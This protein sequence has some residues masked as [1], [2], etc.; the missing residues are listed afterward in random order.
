MFRS[1]EIYLKVSRQEKLDREQSRCE[2]SESYH[3]GDCL[4][5]RTAETVGCQ[6]FWSNLTGHPVCH[7]FQRL[8]SYTE[9][10][11]STLI[12]E[13]TEIAR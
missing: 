8:L 13:Q 5:R 11:K 3:Y 12:M 9:E 10:L 7:S 6:T 4:T 1:V 2:D